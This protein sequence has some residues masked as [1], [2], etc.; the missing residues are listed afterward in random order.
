M[1]DYR[2]FFIDGNW[3]ESASSRDLDVINPATDQRTGVIRLGTAADV[4]AAVR[5]AR[6]AFDTFSLTSRE[7][8]IA[9]LRRIIEVMHVHLPRLGRVIS[10]EMG[11]PLGMSVQIQAGSGIGHFMAAL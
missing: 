2:K 7:D 1:H 11:A 8:R 4:D 5:A 6:A 10:E 9:L 3:V